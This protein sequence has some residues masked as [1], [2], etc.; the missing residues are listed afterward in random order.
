MKSVAV[1]D[2]SA[3]DQ[4]AGSAI[5][6][7]Y[8]DYEEQQSGDDHTRLDGIYRKVLRDTLRQ[9]AITDLHDSILV[10]YLDFLIR[11]HPTAILPSLERIAS[12]YRPC[13][14]FFSDAFDTIAERSSTPHEDLR[15]VYRLWRASSQSR[16]DDKVDATLH[17][18][19]WLLAHRQGKEA[20]DVVDVMRREVG[21]DGNALATLERGWAFMLD[22]AERYSGDE[23]DDD[24]EM[25]QEQEQGQE[26][27]GEGES[28][29]SEESESGQD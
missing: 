23:S 24:V 14:S 22:N 20:A 17:W 8:L 6:T 9:T 2:L 5:W 11:H 7:S 27:E 3:E 18:A 16:N 15:V 4:S 28:G 19:E 12:T 25:E 29:D 10:K 26:G 1:P 21:N 13:H